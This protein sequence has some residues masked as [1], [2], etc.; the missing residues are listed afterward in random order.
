MIFFKQILITCKKYLYH[1]N[2]RKWVK[3]IIKTFIED[4]FTNY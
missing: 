1:T 3:D 4:L 2:I